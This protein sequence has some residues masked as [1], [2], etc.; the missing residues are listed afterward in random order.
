M[1]ERSRRHHFWNSPFQLNILDSDFLL[2]TPPSLSCRYTYNRC[3]TA[4][5][6]NTKLPASQSARQSV[7]PSECGFPTTGPHS[8]LPASCSP[9]RSSSSV[10]L[11]HRVATQGFGLTGVRWVVLLWGFLSYAWPPP[12]SHG[13]YLHFRQRVCPPASLSSFFSFQLLFTYVYVDLVMA[14]EWE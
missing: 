10:I 11:A 12:S 1:Q 7:R 8:S 6:V 2:S 5:W 3:C 14:V 13:H 9:A 4:C